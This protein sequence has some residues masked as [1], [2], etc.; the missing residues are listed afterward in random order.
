MA[1]GYQNK[2][3]GFEEVNLLY[4]DS[5]LNNIDTNGIYYVGA[6]VPNSPSDYSM[7]L[8]IGRGANNLS[9]QIVVGVD[10]YFR[11]RIGNPL[12]WSSWFLV[13]KAS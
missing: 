11:I 8:V 4:S 1:E 13:S 10:M 6:N 5:D 12:T 7:L 2:I 9:T 3:K